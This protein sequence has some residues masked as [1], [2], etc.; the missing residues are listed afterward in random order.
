MVKSL[1]SIFMQCLCLLS[2]V[3]LRIFS[4]VTKVATIL[5]RFSRFQHE[6]KSSVMMVPLLLMAVGLCYALMALTNKIK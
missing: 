6:L 5:G 3:F 4:N 1:K 2:N